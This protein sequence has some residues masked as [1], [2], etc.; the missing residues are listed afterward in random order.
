MKH[1]IAYKLSASKKV[2][3]LTLS[4]PNDAEARL[5]LHDLL[6]IR[7]AQSGR[8]IAHVYQLP[9]GRAFRRSGKFS[10]RFKTHAEANTKLSDAKRS[11]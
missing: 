1:E 5:W 7:V 10:P 11:L 3:N 6:A 8:F 2:I 4:I 9:P